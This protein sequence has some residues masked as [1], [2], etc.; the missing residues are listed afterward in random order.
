MQKIRVGFLYGGVSVEHEISIISCLQAMAALDKEKYEIVPLYISK[1]GQWYTGEALFQM[2]AYKDMPSLLAKCQSIVPNINR[3]KAAF[4]VPKS[5]LF[6]KW[7]EMK[8]DVYFPVIHGSHGEDGC[9]Q[10]FLEL[11]GIPYVGPNVL[12]AALG[13][14]KVAMKAVWKDAGLPVAPYLYFYSYEWEEKAHILMDQI[15]KELSY[16]VIVKP[17]NLGSS[18]GISIAKDR[19]ALQDALDF[20]AQFTTRLLVEKVVPNLRE[21]NCAVLGLPQSMEVS[22]CEEP[23]RGEAEFLDY[24]K[25][26]GNGG[27]G[28]KGYSKN[29]PAKTAE[30]TSANGPSGGMSNLSRQVPA[31]ISSELTAK[32]QELAKKSFVALD[33]SGVARI[34]FLY[35]DVAQELYLNEIN[36]IPGSL[37]FYLWDPAGKDFGQLMEDLLQTAW[38]RQRQ[39]EKLTFSYEGNILSGMAPAG[40]KGGGKI[41]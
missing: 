35:D 3:N 7:E 39:K 20:A 26:Y 16:P 13:M 28:T 5:G 4:Y 21:F 17:A 37:S 18:V 12:G 11:T 33:G 14:D 25:K 1:D 36:T 40:A 10:G 24:G 41:S 19:T 29:A 2:D 15:E 22:C 31:Q 23:I 32:I 9:L 30:A 34:D 38:V 27:K 8:I 6:A